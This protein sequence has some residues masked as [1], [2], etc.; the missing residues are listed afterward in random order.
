MKEKRVEQG[1]RKRSKGG[2]TSARVAG[3]RLMRTRTMMMRTGRRKTKAAGNNVAENWVFFVLLLH[4]S[5]ASALLG[6][7][8]CRSV[9]TTL[10]QVF[11]V[12]LTRSFV[13]YSMSYS[14]IALWS[15]I[16]QYLTLVHEECVPVRCSFAPTLFLVRHR[17]VS[18]N[19]ND[20]LIPLNGE[21]D[22]SPENE[23]LGMTIPGGFCQSRSSARDSSSVKR[24]V[25]LEL[26]MGW[27]GGLITRKSQKRNKECDDYRVHHQDQSVR[28][29]KLSL[30]A[31]ST[32]AGA[33]VSL[34]V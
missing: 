4:V 9:D 22:M 31:Y 33:P 29:M 26:S 12:D 23:Y 17:G 27:F 25:L 3:T 11:R 24:G 34:W 18:D 5:F 6:S 15:W 8:L 1:A 30:D 21:D 7:L 16:P 19:G 32:K 14:I 20:P 13:A 10:L 2:G 28:S